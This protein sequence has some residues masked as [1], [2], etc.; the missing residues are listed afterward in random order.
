MEFGI[1]G[2]VALITG[3]DSGIGRSTAKLL[4]QEGVKIVLLDLDGKQLEGTKQDV[5]A[6]GDVMAIEADLTDLDAVK[7][8]KSQI[9][10]HFGRVDILVNCAGITGATGEFLNITDD[11]WHNA[12]EVNLMGAVRA[13]RAFIPMMLDSGWG[14]VVL[15]T[16][17]DATQPYT[18][19][20][21]YSAAKAGVLNFA[22]NLSKA[23]ASQGVLVNSVSPAY[24]ATPM[25]DAMMEKRAGELG[26]SFDEA[27]ASFLKE[28]RPHLELQR[29]G[30]AQEVAAVIAF[31]CS[32]QASFVVGSNYRVDG[33]SVTGI[34]L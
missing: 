26:V 18:D 3:G 5:A 14:R 13:C 8:A 31:L 20:M 10:E 11:E 33:G 1:K 17:E 4:A 16:S 22:K 2:K 29:R 19:E 24:I 9:V 27:I 28:K 7:A 6:I 21:P 30:K 23:Y 15:M 25:T 34:S 32:E 12:I